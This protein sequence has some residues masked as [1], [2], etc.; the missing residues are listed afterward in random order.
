MAGT[1]SLVAS[2]WSCPR[3]LYFD[4]RETL[5]VRP[6]AAC[7]APMAARHIATTS[8]LFMLLAPRVE[9]EMDGAAFAAFVPSGKSRATP[10][11]RATALVSRTKRHQFGEPSAAAPRRCARARQNP[12]TRQT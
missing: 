9:M 3:Y 5:A 1:I 7:A 2:L 8:D 12:R 6:S 11:R 4:V 10:H